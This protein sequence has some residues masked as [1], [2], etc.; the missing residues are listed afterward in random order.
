MW[1]LA[2]IVLIKTVS[3]LFMFW[4]FQFLDSSLRRS[5]HKKWKILLSQTWHFSMG[6]LAC[7]KNTIHLLILHLS[8]SFIFFLLLLPFWTFFLILFILVTLQTPPLYFKFDI[9]LDSWVLCLFFSLQCN[10]IFH[11]NQYGIWPHQ[12]YWLVYNNNNLLP[13]SVGLDPVCGFE[14]RDFRRV[15]VGL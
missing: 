15:W 8:I 14:V 6:S 13:S 2:I 11:G 12:Q 4:C 3:A 7:M 9:P 10:I 1:S 5:Q